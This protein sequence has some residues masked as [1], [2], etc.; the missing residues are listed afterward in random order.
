MKNTFERI[1]KKYYP[2]LAARDE[3]L[4][5]IGEYVRPD[6]H[7]ASTVHSIYFDTDSY[8]VI[9]NSVEMPRYK[10]K[11]RLR[12]YGEL[13]DSTT[14]FFEIKKKWNHVVYKRRVP[15]NMTAVRRYL[16]ESIFP[17]I[18]CQIMREIDYQI[19]SKSL[20]PRVLVSYDRIAYF[21]N[22]DAN[23]RVSFDT[24][25]TAVKL[26]EDLS[27]SGEP[28]CL[29]DDNHCIMEI[30]ALGGWP[31]WFSKLMSEKRIF[32]RRFS[33]YGAYYKN[34]LYKEVL[35]GYTHA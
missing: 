6:R 7:G 20:R 17:E 34:T 22:D 16:A 2:T 31:V 9:C 23:F 13:N 28:E 24:H 33:K 3:V 19:K 35:G 11:V 32:H 29:I 14:V 18:D 10:E 26:N 21:A 1:E 8:S 5:D 15:M 27:P 30:K 12:W 25:I 4:A